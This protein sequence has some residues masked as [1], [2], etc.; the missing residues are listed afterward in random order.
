METFGSD[1]VQLVRV[2]EESTPGD[3]THKPEKITKAMLRMSETVWCG[4]ANFCELVFNEQELNSA[5]LSLACQTVTQPPSRGTVR[6]YEL[7]L[8]GT[9]AR[10]LAIQSD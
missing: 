8:H 2:I 4:Y 7:A 5:L 3:S 1:T 9:A 6:S 10:I